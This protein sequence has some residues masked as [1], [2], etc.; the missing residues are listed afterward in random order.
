MKNAKKIFGFVLVLAALGCFTGGVIELKN[1]MDDKVYWENK[2]AKASQD[3]DT[4]EDGLK[5]LQANQP[6]YLAGRTAYQTG[7]TD[8]EKGQQ[9]L[10]SGQAE[11]DAGVATLAAKQQ[12]YDEGLAQLQAA[13]QQLAAGKKTLDDNYQ[14]YIDGKKAVAEGEIKLANSRTEI[15]NGEAELNKMVPVVENVNKINTSYENWVQGYQALKNFQNAQKAIGKSL[16]D[17]SPSANTQYDQAIVEAHVDSLQGIPAALQSGIPTMATAIETLFT[18]IAAENPEL[19]AQILSSVNMTQENLAGVI[20]NIKILDQA[21][22]PKFQTDMEKIA[23]A[24]N[25]L[26]N[27]YDTS[28]ATLAAG[29][30]E[31]A[32]GE[33]ELATG[34]AKIAE[35]EQGQ[36][37]Y[38]QG[39]AEYSAGKAKLADGATQL[40]AG[41]QQL[42]D[43]ADT[44]ENGKIQ[45]ADAEKQLDDG[46]AQLAE[47]E[48]GRDQAID[49][50]KTAL[51]T[52][53]YGDLA[54]I[55]DRVGPNFTYVADN[56]DL[57]LDRGLFAVKTARTFTSDNTNAV[58][59]DL[60]AKT[61]VAV[62]V[63]VAGV[64]SLIASIV[65]LRHS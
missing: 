22:Y 46:K 30:Q 28:V 50:I 13:E 1:A 27:F 54:S 62:V 56:G 25:A 37:E 44:I 21:D 31:Y 15:A 26:L 36:A 14:A 18:Q 42:A 49:G 40:A 55:A 60:T 43:A 32:A 51:A 12:E 9:D 29:K 3:L 35:Y 52:E 20:A 17:P 47:F 59:H 63:I 53:T 10:A 57:D 61:I 24:S 4:L 6:A 34:K 48:T 19:T 45:L 58:T 11:Y 16:P 2:G 39:L 5:T 65:L 38:A 23:V 7:L 8:Y 33:A 64:I 41:R